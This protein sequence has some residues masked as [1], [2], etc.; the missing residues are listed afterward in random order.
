MPGRLL[1]PLHR[2]RQQNPRLAPDD[3]GGRAAIDPAA[4]GFIATAKVIQAITAASLALILPTR[5]K[6]AAAPTGPQANCP[7]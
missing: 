7:E 3:W 1:A 4:P 5:G 6:L 2:R